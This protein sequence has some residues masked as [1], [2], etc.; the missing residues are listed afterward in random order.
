MPC[1]DIYPF[2][3]KASKAKAGKIKT[4]NKIHVN[5]LLGLLVEQRKI[6]DNY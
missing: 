4:R 5:K 1:F 6:N 2:L 3:L